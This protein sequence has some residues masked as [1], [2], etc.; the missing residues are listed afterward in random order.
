MRK[1]SIPILLALA[2]AF[3]PVV[4]LAA[5][6]VTLNTVD[7]NVNG[8]G[9]G[10]TSGATMDQIV[11]SD[12]SFTTTMSS[13]S[14]L[15]VTSGARRKLTVSPSNM[16]ISETC[17]SSESSVTIGSPSTA[18]AVA[19]TVDVSSNTCSGTGSSSGSSGGG[20]VGIT[21]GSSG[22]SS[23]PTPTPV[24]PPTAVPPAAPV[25][26]ADAAKIVAAATAALHSAP[27]PIVEVSSGGVVSALFIKNLGPGTTSADVKRLQQLLNSNSET[28]IAETGSGSP[29]HESS[30]YGALT[31]KA[32]Q[33]FQTKYGLI[34]EGTPS[35]TGF[36][37][38]GPKT[39]A[40]IE[41]YLG[42]TTGGTET[43][44]SAAALAPTPTVPTGAP[45]VYL[46]GA[47]A[48]GKTHNDVKTLQ[49]VLNGDI[50]TQI[51]ATGIGSPGNETDF[52]GG[53]TEKA[54]QK[55]QVKHGIAAPGD[56]GYGAVGPKTR[57][58]INELFGQ[59]GSMHTEVM[60]PAATPPSST[61]NAAD[62]IQN[63]INAAL[64]KVSELQSQVGAQSTV[65]PAP[66]VVVPAPAVSNDAAAIQ[67]QIDD[68]MK[69]IQEISSQL[70]TA[71]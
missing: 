39:R 18:T 48:K 47:L 54:V 65:A 22:G 26:P 31:V 44:S 16:A 19:V 6:D 37:A 68:A 43:A 20:V 32:V 4:T 30:F 1:L 62:D 61:G 53:M 34:T 42:G 58:K 28:R 69:K 56:P 5:N 50:E 11:V 24:P 14:S 45:M 36:G 55:F 10:V 2:V 29:G 38:V 17:T 33:K 64:K 7:L 3:S 25:T 9:L 52:F 60:T 63:Q 71:S 41:M 27:P 49:Q 57:A 66:P 46:T 35:T 59:Q 15:K 70:K 13:G 21:T 12:S 67:K 51:T 40:A 23:S 8:S